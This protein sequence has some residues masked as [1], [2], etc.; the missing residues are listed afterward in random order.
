MKKSKV[1]ADLLPEGIF[2]LTGLDESDVPPSVPVRAKSKKRNQGPS[3][4]SQ[5][6]KVTVVR[7]DTV[8]KP[9]VKKRVLH[10][11]KVMQDLDMQSP[12][13]PSEANG[14]NI[15]NAVEIPKSLLT[16]ISRVT[17]SRTRSLSALLLRRTV[18][19][20]LAYSAATDYVHAVLADGFKID[21]S[22]DQAVLDTVRDLARLEVVHFFVKRMSVPK[23]IK[24]LYM[25][26]YVEEQARS[27]AQTMSKTGHNGLSSHLKQLEGYIAKRSERSVKGSSE[28]K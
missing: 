12:K 24:D 16:R 25:K 18:P 6:G 21:A 20:V 8:V 23:N 3:A 22:V 27:S 11:P 10:K 15:R 5:L 7:P 17:E 9:A 19:S 14:L 4:A 13:L 26:T 2:G 1:K 28:P